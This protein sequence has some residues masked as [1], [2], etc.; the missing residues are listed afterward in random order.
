VGHQLLPQLP[1]ITAMHSVSTVI[2]CQGKGEGKDSVYAKIIELKT[3]RMHQH[4]CC[5]YKL[6]FVAGAFC[7]K[8]HCLRI[9]QSCGLV[10]LTADEAVLEPVLDE[11]RAWAG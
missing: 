7:I 9:N 8:K 3:S 2:Y 1:V 6:T 10:K 11:I 4:K 5:N